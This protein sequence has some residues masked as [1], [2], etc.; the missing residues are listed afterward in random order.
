MASAFHMPHSFS[1]DEAAERK[2]CAVISSFVKPSLRRAALMVFSLMR[3]SR[4]R[5][6]RKTKR[7]LPGDAVN[8]MQ[9]GN[10]AGCKRNAMRPSHLHLR[11][12]DGP[13]SASEIE[14]APFC[15]ANLTRTRES[16]RQQFQSGLGFWSPLIAGNSPEQ[17][18][19]GFG[20]NYG[21][22]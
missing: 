6:D 9:Q 16:Q 21:R 3:R 18:T 19:E 4:D 1:I 14:L 20:F 22:P 17:A 11:G 10:S 13:T 7:P 5:L 12:R 8:L 15:R 2:P